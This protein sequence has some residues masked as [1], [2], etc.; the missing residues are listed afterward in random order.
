[1]FD[2]FVRIERALRERRET[3]NALNVFP[4]PDADTGTNLLATVQAGREAAVDGDASAIVEALVRGAQGNSGVIVSQVL[5]S[6]TEVFSDAVVIDAATYAQALERASNLARDAVV[7]PVEGTM[8]TAISAAASAA[9]SAVD[10]EWDLAATSMSVCVATAASVRQTTEQLPVLRRASVVDAGARGFELVVAAVHCHLTGQVV[11]VAVDDVPTGVVRAA[12]ASDLF[13]V[14]YVVVAD[15]TVAPRLQRALESVGESVVVGT[16]RTAVQAHVHTEDAGAAIEAA[17]AFGS[18][19]D[20]QVTRLP[21]AGLRLVAE[22]AGDGLARL[23]HAAGAVVVPT[24]LPLAQA[25]AGSDHTVVIGVCPETSDTVHVVEQASTPPA[26]V[27][28]LAVWNPY[29]DLDTALAA[30][31]AAADEVTAVEVAANVTDPLETLAVAC[32]DL[33]AAELVTLLVGANV[34]A[35]MVERARALLVERTGVEVEVID[36]GFKA[37]F[38]VGAE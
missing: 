6:L 4:I 29:T 35:A 30:A 1:M 22:V 27:A 21:R 20:I 28:V 33:A 19:S 12:P 10:A 31:R 13:E 16:T 9:R 3:L 34:D 36:A 5:R 25:L 23:A 17:V 7:A 38:W 18:V 37:W 2:L 24:D 32:E 11:A 15:P 8:L 26:V 14:Q